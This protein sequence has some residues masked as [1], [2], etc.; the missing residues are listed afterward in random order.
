[1]CQCVLGFT[2]IYIPK[3]AAGLI[4][5][6]IKKKKKNAL[7]VKSTNIARLNR[8]SIFDELF[9]HSFNVNKHIKS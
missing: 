3:S 2:T 7:Q 1:M 4:E 8:G 5:I 6:E 9:T